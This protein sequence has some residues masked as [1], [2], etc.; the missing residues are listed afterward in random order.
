MD[1]RSEDGTP[2][3]GIKVRTA[4]SAQG[5]SARADFNAV[6]CSRSAKNP[7]GWLA[8]RANN[9]HGIHF[10]EHNE[11]EYLLPPTPNAVSLQQSMLS[12]MCPVICR[13]VAS[14]P[15]KPAQR[16]RE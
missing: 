1:P 9:E 13:L 6:A 16:G 8:D 10:G 15:R 2:T 5:S 4:R 11:L 7:P 12:K 3:K 14:K